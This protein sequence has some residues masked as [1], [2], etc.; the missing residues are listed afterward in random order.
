[1]A[2]SMARAFVVWQNVLDFG[3]LRQKSNTGQDQPST[4]RAE[5]SGVVARVYVVGLV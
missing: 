3:K 5:S 2:D 1:M 4:H